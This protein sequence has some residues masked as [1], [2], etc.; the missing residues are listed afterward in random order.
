MVHHFDGRRVVFEDGGRVAQRIEQ[1]PILD[2]Q[3][4]LRLRERNEVEPRLDNQSERAFGSDDQPR[5]VEGVRVVRRAGLALFV[6]DKCIEVVAPDAAEDFRVAPLDLGG[7]AR[8]EA[9]DGPIALAF[10]GRCGARGVEFRGSQWPEVGDRFVGKGNPEVHHVVDGLAVADGSRTARVVRDHPADSGAARRRNVGRKAEA[11]R[12]QLR[13]QLVEDNA[14]FNAHPAFVDVHLEQSVE[15][16]RRV[17][18]QTGADRLPR[19]RR[20]AAARRNRDAMRAGAGDGGQHVVAR[21]DDGD[22]ERR[23]LVDAGVGGVE[24]A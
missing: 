16:A 3:H 7:V 4:R 19:L 9:A 22:A 23:D 5:Q 14:R 15:V 17:D 6:A 11:V 13:V 10:V 18:L 20:A 1:I 2:G 8:G 21:P 12:G 24:G